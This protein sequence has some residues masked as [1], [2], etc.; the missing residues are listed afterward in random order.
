MEGFGGADVYA[1]RVHY[2][3]FIICTASNLREGKK[4]WGELDSDEKCKRWEFKVKQERG[5]LLFDMSFV[6]TF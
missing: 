2:S 5:G 3:H 4:G 1:A 6:F